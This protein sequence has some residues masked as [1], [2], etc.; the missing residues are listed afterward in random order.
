MFHDL[1]QEVVVRVAII[2]TGVRALRPIIS[3]PRIPLGKK[4]SFVKAHVLASVLFQCF[5]C[6]PLS[7]PLYSKIQVAVVQVYPGCHS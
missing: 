7:V 4:L 5:T 1:S 6:C 2:R 3:S